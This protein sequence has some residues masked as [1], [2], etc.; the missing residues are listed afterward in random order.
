LAANPFFSAHRID[1]KCQQNGAVR[2]AVALS[3]LVIKAL[4]CPFFVAFGTNQALTHD[5]GT[6]D[7]T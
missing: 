3:A 5:I 6:F 4:A 7:Q 1:N 2:V